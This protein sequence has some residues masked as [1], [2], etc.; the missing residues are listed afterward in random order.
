MTGSDF[1][2]EAVEEVTEDDVRRLEGDRDEL[3]RQRKRMAEALTASLSQPITEGSPGDPQGLSA[4]LAA[5]LGPIDQQLVELRGR[6][7][8]VRG[9]DAV[10]RK[11]DE[12]LVLRSDSLRL[13]S[14]WRV[15][16]IHPDGN[17]LLKDDAT[18]EDKAAPGTWVHRS[19]VSKM[20][21]RN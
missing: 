1:E 8:Y 18:W 21:R 12:V 19:H 7:N 4:A 11:G 14:R 9:H 5:V 17:L 2:P 6:I 3:E 15:A 16:Y 10:Y 13:G 20:S